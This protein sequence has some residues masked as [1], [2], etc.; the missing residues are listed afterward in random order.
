MQRPPRED[1]GTVARQG[2]KEEEKGWD[3]GEMERGGSKRNKGQNRIRWMREGGFTEEKKK[4]EKEQNRK[5][6]GR[7]DRKEEGEDRGG[8]LGERKPKLQHY[9]GADER[10]V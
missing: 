7:I 4:R 6:E 10:F 1:Y 3:K 5:K 2:W 9:T 8:L